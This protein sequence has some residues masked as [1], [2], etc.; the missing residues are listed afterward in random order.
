MIE[1]ASNLADAGKDVMLYAIEHRY[2]GLSLP[3][4]DMTSSNYN[5]YLSSHNAILDVSTFVEMQNEKFETKP[6]WVTFGGSY[7]GMVSAWSRLL[8]PDLIWASVSNSS[9]VQAKLN[10]NEYNDY[11]GKVLSDEDIGGSQECL[12]VVAEGHEQIKEQLSTSSGQEGLVAEFNVCEID[13][14]D[15]PL[16]VDRNAQ[17]FAGDGV[18]YVPAQENDPSC[19]GDLCNVK[20]ICESLLDGPETESAMD[21]LVRVAAAQNGDGCVTVDWESQISLLKS[22]AATAGGTRSWLFQTCNEFGFYQTC[23]EDSSCPYAKGLHPL[24]QDLEM[25]S[26]V[27][28]IDADTVSNNVDASN[29]FYGGWNV[30]SSRILFVNGD[31]DPWSTLAITSTNPEVPDPTK[32]LPAFWVDQA[33]HHFWTH[34]VLPTDSDYVNE[35]RKKIWKQVDQ[36]LQLD[37]AGAC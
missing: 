1:L 5:V 7:P 9:P 11:V 36:W 10:M 25:C 22:L 3:R 27:F 16:S 12:D 17:L 32:C 2:Y 8:F 35:S 33:S 18:I 6:K 29:D 19:T 23:E 13:G 15:N 21:K 28:G 31:V 37:D 20:K 14:L 30:D 4:G 26:S 24:N 34:E